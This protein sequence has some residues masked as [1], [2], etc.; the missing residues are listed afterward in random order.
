MISPSLDSVTLESLALSIS[1][2]TSDLRDKSQGSQV[3]QIDL[4]TEVIPVVVAQDNNKLSHDVTA[5]MSEVT[6][7]TFSV[8]NVTIET[9][10]V[11]NNTEV[12]TPVTQTPTI[13]WSSENQVIVI[14]I[15]SLSKFRI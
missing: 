15:F 1:D 3:G 6:T 14:I 10:K 13:V 4:V 11:T 2:Q 5:A 9:P 8:K 12:E 7:T